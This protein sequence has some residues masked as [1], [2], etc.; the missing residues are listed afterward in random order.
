MDERQKKIMEEYLQASQG[1]LRLAPAWVTRTILPPGKRLKLDVRDL[2]P[3]GLKNG[4]ISE[5]WMASTGM[6]DN[7]ETTGDHEGMSYIVCKTDNGV[8]KIL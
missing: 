2:Y 7:G 5:R 6:V 1:V 8:E 4:A 3:R